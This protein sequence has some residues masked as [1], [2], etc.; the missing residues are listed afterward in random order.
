MKEKL[1]IR[2]I[3]AM[4]GVSK[5][6]VSFVLNNREGVSEETRKKVLSVIEQT[7][8]TPTLNSRRLYYQK[9]FSIA[10]VFDKQAD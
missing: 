10:V 7:N 6:A 4:A 8:Y 5:T 3:A 2:D 9:S 1:T